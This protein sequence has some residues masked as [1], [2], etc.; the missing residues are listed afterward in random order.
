[1]RLYHYNKCLNVS[2]IGKEVLKAECIEIS[3]EQE[4]SAWIVTDIQSLKIRAAGWADYR[5]PDGMETRQNIPELTGME[6]S[7]NSGPR[8]K[9]NSK[10]IEPQIYE[11]ISECIRGIIMSEVY[12]YR[13]RGFSVADDY[14]GYWNQ[15]NAN[16]CRRFSRRPDEIDD[17]RWMN[18]V[19]NTNRSHNLFTRV[20]NVTFHEIDDDNH[21]A[22]ATFIDS[23]HEL[24]IR[25][26]LSSDGIVK[27]AHGVY[28]RTPFKVCKENRSYIDKLIGACLFG[29]AKKDLAALTGGS[30]GCTH[31]VDLLNDVCQGLDSI[32]D[33][34]RQKSSSE[35]K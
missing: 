35:K 23:F 34:F 3:S 8:L 26:V 11:L 20:H 29:K 31:M 24:G 16:T 33:Q 21:L 25:M 19:R 18:Y 10:Y 15:M 4:R 5:S 28:R 9:K 32:K 2:R 17:K 14:L 30:E 22:L 1:M 12:F 27:K 6:V 7:I 13:E